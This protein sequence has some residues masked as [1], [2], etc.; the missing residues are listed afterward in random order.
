MPEATQQ[1]ISELKLAVCDMEESSVVFVRRLFSRLGDKWSFRTLDALANEPLR[2]TALT[3]A[4][5]GISHRVLTVTLRALEGDGMVSR[6]S[7]PE[8]PAR[9]EYAL[10]P[11]GVGFL[12]QAL[13]MVSTLTR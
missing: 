1:S 5:P 2:F 12:R 9:V 10:T 7:Y 13:T 11:L 6:T 4:L 8:S 3:T